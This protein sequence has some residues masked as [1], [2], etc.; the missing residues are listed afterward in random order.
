MPVPERHVLLTSQRNQLF[1]ALQGKGFRPDEFLFLEE[2]NSTR[3]NH[4]STQYGFSIFVGS[5]T[6]SG[7][8]G[9]LDVYDVPYRVLSSPGSEL[10]QEQSYCSSW[11]NVVIEFNNWL[12]R[13]TTELQTPDLWATVSSDTHL[14]RLAADQDNRPFTLEEQFQVKK[15]LNEIKAYLI[16]S[17]NLTAAQMRTVEA[18]FDYMEEAAGRLGRKDWTGI[19]VSNLIGIAITL[20]LSAD[21]AKD[22][23]RFAGQIVKQFLGT[24][25]YLGGPH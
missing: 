21:S 18:R 7:S 22:L 24:V 17:N 4:C 20:M 2:D 10:L 15:A 9:A 6:V 3:L 5:F 13:L 8:M 25:L 19:L 23:I 12:T 11:R 1:T 14:I 16:K